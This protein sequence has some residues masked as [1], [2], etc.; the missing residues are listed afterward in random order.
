MKQVYLTPGPTELHPVVPGLIRQALDEDICSMSHRSKKFEAIF[1]TAVKNLHQLLDIPASFQ[2]FFLGSATEAMERI[3]EN[4]AMGSSCHFVNGE[5][6]KRFYS[7]SQ[8]LKKNPFK[9]EA[10]PGEGFKFETT[11][12]PEKAN[13]VCLTQNETSTGFWLPEED[14]HSLKKQHPEKLFAVDIVSSAPISALDF[15]LIDCAFFSVQKC[16]GL[17]SGLGVLMVNDACLDTAKKI[18]KDNGNIGSYHNFPSLLEYAKINQTPETPNVLS[19]F[20][21]GKVCETYLNEGIS[22][23]RKDAHDKAKLLYDYFDNHSNLKPAILGNKFRSPTVISIN[24]NGDSPRL[25]DFL[26]KAGFHVGLG[27]GPNKN[28]HIR[29]AN[30]PTHSRKTLE[31]LLQTMNDYR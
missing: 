12:I 20:L 24:V 29:I 5:F 26:A 1:S 18:A 16:F 21:L 11:A 19:I 8:D 4:C 2:I 22:N 25:R 13:L 6:S 31:E 17:P 28:S 30:F 27:Y 15:S 9:I 23:I 10:A 7:I 14:I 3:I